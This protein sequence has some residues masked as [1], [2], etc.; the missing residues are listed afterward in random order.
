MFASHMQAFQIT[1]VDSCGCVGSPLG[2]PMPSRD[3]FCRVERVHPCVYVYCVYVIVYLCMQKAFLKYKT[4]IKCGVLSGW[5]IGYSKMTGERTQ[6]LCRTTRASLCV[7]Q[8]TCCCRACSAGRPDTHAERQTTL[9]VLAAGGCLC[10]SCRTFVPAE[11]L[12]FSCAAP[13]CHVSHSLPGSVSRESL[14]WLT[15]SQHCP[16][17][18]AS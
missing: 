6:S 14:S 7:R 1:A 9:T 18:S 11:R 17:A 4:K 15:S 8:V 5:G 3:Y 10:F 16:S 2:N 12:L 13:D